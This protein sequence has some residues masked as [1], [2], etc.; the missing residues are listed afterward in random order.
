[1]DVARQ[2]GGYAGIDGFWKQSMPCGSTACERSDELILSDVWEAFPFILLV[3]HLL[4]LIFF[5]GFVW[6]F[7]SLVFLYFFGFEF[8]L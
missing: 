3:V 2:S 4:S 6:P 1:M 8:S 7:F 5:L